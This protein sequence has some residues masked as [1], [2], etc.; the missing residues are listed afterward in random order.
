MEGLFN[1]GKPL[2]RFPL[3]RDLVRVSVITVTVS[4]GMYL[5]AVSGATLGFFVADWWQDHRYK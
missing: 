5:L 2:G 1:N 4:V 3:G